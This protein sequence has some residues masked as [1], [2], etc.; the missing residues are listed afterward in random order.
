MSTSVTWNGTTYT[1]PAAGELNWSALDTFLIDVGTNAATSV[2]QKQAVRV[3]TASPVS[4][5]ATTDCV[6]VCK[7]TVPAAVAVSLPA[8]V[9]GRIY[10]IIDGT[11]DAATNNITITPNGAETINGGATY[12]INRNYGA[13]QLVYNAT[14]KWQVVGETPKQVVN[15]DVAA[16]A[17]IA[18]SKLNLGTSIVNADVSGSAAIAYSK[19]SLGTSIV[20]ADISA[21]AAIAGSKLVAAAS[22]VAGAVDANTQTFTGIKTFETSIKLASAGGTASALNH[23]EEWTG[24][25]TN[26]TGA[27]TGAGSACILKATRVGRL[28]TVHLPITSSA[29][30]AVGSFVYGET[31]SARFRPTVGSVATI[32]QVFDAG[33]DA[34]TPGVCL[35][36]TGGVITVYRGVGFATNFTVTLTCGITNPTNISYYI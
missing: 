9:A 29:G 10:Q 14:S 19:L 26:S 3:A 1:I 28:I 36:S 35:I 33:V 34:T 22:G 12:V 27:V 23:Y 2:L 8:G 31:L 32:V 13:V 5:S 17:A 7:L 20:N 25:S 21:S 30:T 6:V 18:Y 16:A 4:V 24:S 11:G 15:A